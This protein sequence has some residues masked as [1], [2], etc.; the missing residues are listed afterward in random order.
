MT[1]E[2]LATAM[3]GLGVAIITYAVQKL[4]DRRELVRSRNYSAYV[5][6]VEAICELANAHNRGGIG[7]EEALSNYATAKMKFA[8]VASDGA[9][10]RFVEFDKR[11]TSGKPVPHD[12]FDETLAE[13]MREVRAENIG[14]S[15]L[16][17]QEL[18]IVTPFGRSIGRESM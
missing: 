16:T 3:I 11:I 9:M 13:F 14:K 15:K 5:E 12:V 18:I 10:R 7:K 2:L 1:Q 4:F 17:N 8:I 6:M